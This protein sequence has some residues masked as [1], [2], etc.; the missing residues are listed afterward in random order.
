MNNAFI[1]VRGTR[2]QAI[3]KKGELALML[4]TRRILYTVA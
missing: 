2:C 3:E 4:A 1:F